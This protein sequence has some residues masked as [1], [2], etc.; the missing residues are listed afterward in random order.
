MTLLTLERAEIVAENIKLIKAKTHWPLRFIGVGKEL[1]KLNLQDYHRI[2]INDIG[3]ALVACLYLDAI[4][5]SKTI[6]FLHGSEPEI[7][8]EHPELLHRLLNFKFQYISLL[9]HSKHVIAVSEYMKH[10]FLE[11]TALNVLADK[12]TVIANGVDSK[13]F[14]H[15]NEGIRHKFDIPDD[16]KLLLSV[17]RLEAGKGYARMLRIFKNLPSSLNKT[18]WLVA[19]DGPYR[20]EMESFV[21]TNKLD[22]RI[23]FAGKVDRAQL[24]LFY[25]SANVFWLLSEFHESLGLVYIEANFCGVPAIGNNKGGVRLIIKNGINGY[26]LEENND[27]DA[28]HTLR[29]AIESTWD[30]NVISKSVAEFEMFRNNQKLEAMID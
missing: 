4:S 2:V 19:G 20:Q 24:P 28:I 6:M 23:K 22:D 10:K 5:I 13:L 17:S 11:R 12:I 8:F 25:S 18:Y 16:A 15:R 9:S 3:A 1:K 14:K 29:K 21:K 30:S 26:L 27:D 7:V